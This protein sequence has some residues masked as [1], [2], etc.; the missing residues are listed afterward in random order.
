MIAH[1]RQDTHVPVGQAE[2]MFR[3]VSGHD[4]PVWPALYD[5][6]GHENFPR[7]RDHGNFNFYSW[8]RFVETFLMP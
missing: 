7:S 6:E 4:V 8:I 3:A 1:G 5:D 2:S